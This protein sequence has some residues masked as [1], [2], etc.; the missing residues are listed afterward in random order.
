M[1]GKVYIFGQHTGSGSR[2]DPGAAGPGGVPLVWIV[3]C[4]AHAPGRIT[5][6]GGGRGEEGALLVL[7]ISEKNKKQYFLRNILTL[8]NNCAIVES[9]K[10]GNQ[11]DCNGSC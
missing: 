9:S 6:Q 11:Y 1:C 10:G 3:A 4:I 5:P 2:L 7:Q 8:R